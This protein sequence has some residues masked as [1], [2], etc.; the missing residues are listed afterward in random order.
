MAG[1]N[2]CAIVDALK[3]M[4]QVMAQDNQ[5]LLANQQAHQNKNGRADEFPG[6][7]KLQKYNPH[8]FKGIYD[9]ECAQA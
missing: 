5:A 2:D 6:L 9:P 1:K 7:A 4:A 3:E 8:T